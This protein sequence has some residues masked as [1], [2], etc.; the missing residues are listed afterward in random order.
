MTTNE[1]NKIKNFLDNEYKEYK[2]ISDFSSG[3]RDC[4]DIIINYPNVQKIEEK[5]F[6]LKEFNDEKGN[7]DIIDPYYTSN[8]TYDRVI[9]TIDYYVEHAIYK[10]IQMNESILL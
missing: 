6:T 5:T 10:I 1:F 4:K 8:E 3:F 2:E 9:K 7:L